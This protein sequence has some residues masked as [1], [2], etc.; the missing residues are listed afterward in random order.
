M[1]ITEIAQAACLDPSGSP[2]RLNL[3]HKRGRLRH[4]EIEKQIHRMSE[5]AEYKEMNLITHPM[6]IKTIA[7]KR[8]T[9]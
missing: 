1:T 7:N 4:L 5:Q 8:T 3:R 6:T 9:T 2:S